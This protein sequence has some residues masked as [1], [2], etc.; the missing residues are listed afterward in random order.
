MEPPQIN[1]SN[2]ELTVS[3]TVG[4][5]ASISHAPNQ[6]IDFCGLDF[7]KVFVQSLSQSLAQLQRCPYLQNGVA[8]ITDLLF[9][10][11]AVLT[12][13]CSISFLSNNFLTISVFFF[14]KAK[15]ATEFVPLVTLEQ[16]ATNVSLP[17]D[18][19]KTRGLNLGNSGTSGC[20]YNF[21]RSND[22][23]YTLF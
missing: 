19:S 11:F 16:E 13:I 14:A 20:Y 22:F 9:D 7:K 8:L 12:V 6:E 21:L 17:G 5:I 10:S 18:I 2:Y 3:G 15:S 1:N 4:P 23:D